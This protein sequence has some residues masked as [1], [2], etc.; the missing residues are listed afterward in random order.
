M[1][2]LSWIEERVS[3]ESLEIAPGRVRLVLKLSAVHVTALLS[4]LEALY[5][6]SGK[7]LRLVVSEEWTIFWKMRE[8]GNRLLLA[9]PQPQEWVGTIA[10]EKHA[11]QSLVTQLGQ[12]E[13][14]LALVVHEVLPVQ[15]VSNLVLEIQ[16]ASE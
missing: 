1:P 16:R 3:H 12:L 9:H 11:G 2:F 6:Q 7:E 4:H 8:E 14:G 15:G 5:G 10:L 13:A